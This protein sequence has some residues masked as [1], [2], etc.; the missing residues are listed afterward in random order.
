MAAL[1]PGGAGVP[2]S[3]RDLSAVSAP[4]DDSARQGL[5]P[6]GHL[7]ALLCRGCGGLGSSL[8]QGLVAARA[9]ARLRGVERACHRDPVANHS[10]GTATGKNSCI[11]A[12]AA[13]SATETGE[14]RHRAAA[15]VLCRY[16]G[17]A[18]EGGLVGR[19]LVL[20]A[21]GGARTG[22]DLH[23]KLWRCERGERVPAGCAG[24]HQRSPE[25]LLLGAAHLYGQRH[26]RLWR[27]PQYPRKRV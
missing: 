10:P 5:L 16:A 24:G 7:S 13:S 19:C 8:P 25:L 18:A 11:S 17:L 3:G 27:K 26:D 2:L 6:C 4:D 1:Q 22:R 20:A 9:R 21:A 14:W 12:A 15:A 23:G